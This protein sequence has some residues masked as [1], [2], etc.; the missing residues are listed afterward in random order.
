MH[1]SCI[2]QKHSRGRRRR[3]KEGKGRNETSFSRRPRCVRVHIE[4]RLSWRRAPV[5]AADW[6]LDSS[7]SSFASFFFQQQQ[8]RTV[9]DNILSRYGLIID[10]TGREMMS[11]DIAI[12]QPTTCLPACLRAAGCIHELELLTHCCCCCCCCWINNSTVFLFFAFAFAILLHLQSK[13]TKQTD[14]I[15]EHT[16][17]ERKC[18]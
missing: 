7:R 14:K 3:R 1:K 2:G 16:L 11:K 17:L 12:H 10:E 8:R 18:N 5:M 13:E 9:R 6:W 15:R 4:S